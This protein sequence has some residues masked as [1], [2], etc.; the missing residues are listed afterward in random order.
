MARRARAAADH[1]STEQGWRLNEAPSRLR[2]A[3]SIGA[4]R[5][6]CS[7]TSAARRRTTARYLGAR[8]IKFQIIPARR[9]TKK[10]GQMDRGG[11]TGRDD[12]PVCAHASRSIEPRLA[13]GDRRRTCSSVSCGDPHWEKRAAQV[14]GSRARHAVRPDGL[15]QPA[16]AATAPLDPQARA[17]DL[18]PR[19]AGG[20][21]FRDA[22]AVLRPQPAA[23]RGDREPGAQV[24]PAG[25]A[26][27]RRADPRVLRRAHP[28][29]TSTTAPASRSGAR[30]PS[31]RQPEAAVPRR[32][33]T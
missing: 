12:A 28:A 5:R 11:G 23:G 4:A 8:G 17:R 32:A 21:R 3:A 15:R 26:G 20:G 6:A 24:A 31:A 2:A 19:R 1:A 29:R 9:W 13:R 27:G 25:R 22:R 14:V 18:H 10:A 30:R 33:K 16:R 7:A